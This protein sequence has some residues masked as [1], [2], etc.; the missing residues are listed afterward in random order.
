MKKVMVFGTFDGLH[1]G[2]RAML[3]EAKKYGNY[4]IVAVAPNKMIKELKGR[5]PK[6]NQAKRMADLKKEASVDQV[7]KGDREV[8]E[9]K[10]VKKYRPEVIACGYD[11]INLKKCLKKDLIK[12]GFRSRIIS[13]R[14]FKPEKYHS[15]LLETK[16]V[17]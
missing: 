7:I 5:L 9:W 14:P 13:L 2:H 4:L 3:K 1:A 11:Q 16:K 15:T 6:L 8:R 12:L 10:V 17:C